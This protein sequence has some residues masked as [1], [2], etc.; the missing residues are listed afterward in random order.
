MENYK[1][2]KTNK[3]HVY[4]TIWMNFTNKMLSK[5]ARPE[6]IYIVTVPFI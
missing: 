3:L 4:S 6:R 5:E 2:M 1:V